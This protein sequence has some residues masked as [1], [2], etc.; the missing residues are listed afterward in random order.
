M[1]VKAKDKIEFYGIKIYDYKIINKNI[2]EEIMTNLELE[3]F[4]SVYEKD[5]YSFCLS[6]TGNG[7]LADDL[8]QDTFL[9]A[10]EKMG[11]INSD[12]NI[13]SYLLSV[14]VKIWTN[15]K[16]KFAWRKRIVPTVMLSDV[17]E[18]NVLSE[19]D[20][21]QDCVDAEIKNAVNSAVMGLDEKYKIPV[22][23]YY[24]EEMSVTQ[25]A[26]IMKIPQGT[27]KSRLSTARKYLKKEL[28]EYRNE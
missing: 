3:H 20:I 27:V 26:E 11:Q 14:A 4:I 15:R 25:I 21:L 19:T 13:K 7:S 9:K 12:G 1:A 6:L 16:R 18:N 8:Y 10:V 24:M 22:L 23:L 17:H 28:E 2:R 5:I